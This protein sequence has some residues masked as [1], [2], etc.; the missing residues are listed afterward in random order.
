MECGLR[1]LMGRWG[2]AMVCGVVLWLGAGCSATIEPL[3]RAEYPLPEDVDIAPGEPGRRGGIFVMAESQQPRHFHPLVDSDAYTSMAIAYFTNGL[4]TRDPVTDEF[5]GALARDW[6]VGE[7]GLT[8]T[9]HLRRGV[10]WS[11]GEPF[12]ADDV[13]FTFDAIYDPRYPNRSAQQYRIN[14]EPFAYRKIDRYTVEFRTP[15]IYAPFINDIGWA[16][17][18][19]RHILGEAFADGTFQ[20]VWTSET[21]IHEPEKLV[22]TGPFRIRSYRPGERIV[23][24]ANPHYWRADTAGQRLPYIDYLILRFVPDQ[25]TQTILFATGQTDYAAI[26]PSDLDWVRRTADVYDFSLYDRGPATGI[27]FIWFNLHPGATEEGTPFVP[28]HKLAWFSNRYFRHAIAHGIDRPGL[29]RAAFFGRGEPLHSIISPANLRWHNPQTVRYDYDPERA[30]QILLEQ[31]FVY[32][33]N[34]LFD[35]EGNRVEF[36]L[37]LSQGT[38]MT[39]GLSN[40]FRENMRSIG[41]EVTIRTF[42]FG[43]LIQRISQTFR[44]EAASIGFT[45]GGD[46]SGGKAIY[47]SDGHLHLW[48][49]S[50]PEPATEWEARIDAIMDAQERELD[51]ARRQA[52][53]FEMQDIFAEELPLIFLVTPNTYAGLKNRWRNLRIPP[54]GALIWNLDELWAEVDDD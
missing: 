19:P 23:Y 39:E 13:I 41:I 12:T 5:I 22:G 47:R 42:D 52:L 7:D 31:G 34:Q 53:I 21:G 18:V 3:E 49:P 50:Q 32:R 4:V 54:V 2:M 6:E 10:R 14:G 30:R 48:H 38:Q 36:S 40:T 1:V 20:E 17:I 11:D 28:P 35:A 15:D 43:A 37:S 46:P 44:Y 51:L 9:F 24:E 25:N 16:T 45:G 26:S 33:G 8:Y 29:I 27:S